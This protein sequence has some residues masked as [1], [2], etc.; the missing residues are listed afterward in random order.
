MPAASAQP[1]YRSAAH[2]KAVM[3]HVGATLAPTAL[4]YAVLG[5]LI[6]ITLIWGSTFVALLCQAVTT[7]AT[8][9]ATL[10]FVVAG[11]W[12]AYMSV[13]LAAAIAGVWVALLSPFAPDNPR[14]WSGAAI[15]GMMSTFLFAGADAKVAVLGGQLFLALVGAVSSFLGAWFLQNLVLKR[16]D[17]RRDV[18]ARD[19]ADRLARERAAKA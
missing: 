2:R 13:A 16:D 19:R 18:L 17:M 14:F 12:S 6:G 15:I 7:P 4:A 10:T 9:P 5:P 11:V 3:A 8:L 1:I